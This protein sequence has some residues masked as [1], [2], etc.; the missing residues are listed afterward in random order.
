MKKL[1]EQLTFSSYISKKNIYD[2]YKVIKKRVKNFNTEHINF[3]LNKCEFATFTL[4]DVSEAFQFFDSQNARGKPLE[5]YDLLK[6]YH[7]MK[8]P[9]NEEK[10]GKE[11]EKK[12]V[13]L[14]KT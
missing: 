3:L 5:P 9:I 12:Q 2:N 4:D 1:E 11:E 8:Y 6:A 10:T 7:L 14:I 13:R